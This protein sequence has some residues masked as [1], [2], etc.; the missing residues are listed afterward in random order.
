MK[1]PAT[2]AATIA[3][4]VALAGVAMAADVAWRTLAIRG[5]SD[6]SIE[7]PDFMKEDVAAEKTVK[8][9]QGVK[10]PFVAS[11]IDHV[12]GSLFC[13]L[14]RQFYAHD[15]RHLTAVQSQEL[16]ARQLTNDPGIP[17]MMSRVP[18]RKYEQNPRTAGGFAAASCVTIYIDPDNK[19]TKVE[20]I[21]SDTMIAAP[22]YLYKFVCTDYVSRRTREEVGGQFVWDQELKGQV[23]HMV[24]SLKL[25]TR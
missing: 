7:V 8:P 20:V 24:D 6:A 13:M 1:R 25:P 17:C 14:T 12:G 9:A 2:L 23:T 22:R 21:E 15:K 10:I 11:G 4:V 3:A 16:T 18:D 19:N 5:V